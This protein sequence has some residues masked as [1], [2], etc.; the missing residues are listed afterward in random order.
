MQASCSKTLTSEE[1]YLLSFL[2]IIPKESRY[3]DLPNAALGVLYYTLLLIFPRRTTLLRFAS[4]G[5]II[6]SLVLVWIL[7]LKSEVCLLCIFSHV[8]NFTIFWK[9]FMGEGEKR[10][11]RD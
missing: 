1:A 7:F 3:L 2:G 5:S 8:V 9:V 4:L 6:T 11:K 10:I